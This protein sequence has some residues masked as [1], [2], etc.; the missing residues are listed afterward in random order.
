MLCCIWLIALTLTSRCTHYTKTPHYLL[1]LDWRK[2][3]CQELGPHLYMVSAVKSTQTY[4]SACATQ[5]LLITCCLDWHKHW[6]R[7]HHTCTWCQHSKVHRHTTALF[8][9]LT[10]PDA[11]LTMCTLILQDHSFHPIATY[12]CLLVLTA[13][14]RPY[15]FQ[16]SQHPL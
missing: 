12:T 14:Q 2:H 6:C 7:E 3:W 10:T 5:D 15:P 11:S 16:T 13:G 1:C 4:S 8:S 9:K